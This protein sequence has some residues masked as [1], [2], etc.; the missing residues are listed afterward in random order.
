ME[1]REAGFE[2]MEH[3]SP[4]GHPNGFA[5]EEVWVYGVGSQEDTP[6]WTFSQ[7]ASTVTEA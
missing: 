1:Q 4:S 5:H 6:D 3:E 7:R 2:D